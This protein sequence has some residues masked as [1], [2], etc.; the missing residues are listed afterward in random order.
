MAFTAGKE[1]NATFQTLGVAL[2]CMTVST[3]VMIFARQVRTE[4]GHDQVSY[5]F[6]A[7]RF[8]SGA[9][10]YGPQLSETNPP[11]IIWF[12]VPP[13]LLA[14]LFHISPQMA[15]R[16]IVFVLLGTCVAWSIS[17]LR[18]SRN[19][20]F[21]SYISLYLFGVAMLVAGF[22]TGRFDFG[23]R[24]HLLVLFLLPYVLAI[25]SGATSRI[26]IA[27]RCAIGGAAGIAI[28]F[29]PHDVLILVVLELFLALRTHSLRRVRAPEFLALVLTCGLVFSLVLV[30]TPLYC[31]Q[32]VPL[33]IDTYWALG[34]KTTLAL[35]L[36]L[37][38]YLALVFALLIL[39][40]LFR[41]MLRDYLILASLLICSLAASFAFDLQHTDW[42]YHR[43]PHMAFLLLALVYLVIDLLSPFLDK[44][45]SN[46]RSLKMALMGA[47][48]LTI[49]AQAIILARP[50]ARPEVTELSQI[51]SQYPPSTTVYVFSM[52]VPALATA[53]NH[54]LNWGSR[55]AHLWMMPA[56]IQN[57]LGHANSSAPF[58]RLSP[59]KL[60]TIAE[61]QRSQSTDDL[62]HW[63][64]YV[65]LVEHCDSNHSCQGIEGRSFNMISWFLESPQFAEAWSHYRQQPTTTQNFD[66]YM[67]VR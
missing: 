54:N 25:A 9:Q 61:L 49:A 42:N 6:E 60:A 67:R 46:R 31:K 62:N 34:T 20:V 35:A 15:F 51:L 40:F 32:I 55:F 17:I 4:L 39:C 30:T 63:K 24:E 27:E 13:V 11:V 21:A 8:L 57:E 5:I 50:R 2:L 53:Y 14:R 58:K 38:V 66:L 28:W 19:P 10:P 18:R 36:T 41:R 37:K 52:R 33:L 56:I 43:Y 1:R 29:K 22:A 16:A 47:L 23:Q 12:S 26:P 7:Q 48:A 65:V 45:S 64:P 59:E 44:L 3:V